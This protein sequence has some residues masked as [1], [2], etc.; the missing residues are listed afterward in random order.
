MRNII[1]CAVYVGTIAAA[2]LCVLANY[3]TYTVLSGMGLPLRQ[4]AFILFIEIVRSLPAYGMAGLILWLEG[5]R[6]VSWFRKQNEQRN[7]GG[8]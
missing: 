1:E 4:S 5:K 3:T 7:A 8:E 6:A 2:C